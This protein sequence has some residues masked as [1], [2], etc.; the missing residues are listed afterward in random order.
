[1]LANADFHL[2]RKEAHCRQ[3]VRARVAVG[4]SGVIAS[5]PSQVG[6]DKAVKANYDRGG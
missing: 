6:W 4:K 3:R 1:M 2:R 5:L